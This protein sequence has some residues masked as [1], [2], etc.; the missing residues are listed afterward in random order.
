MHMYVCSRVYVCM[1]LYDVHVH[2]CACVPC[3]RVC[4]NSITCAHALTCVY[5]HVHTNTSMHICISSYTCLGQSVMYF[6]MCAYA[7]P[8]MHACGAGASHRAPVLVHA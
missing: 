8:V 7:F 2:V 4:I 5:V 3:V 6:C 1:Y